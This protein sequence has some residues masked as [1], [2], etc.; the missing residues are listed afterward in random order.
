MRRLEAILHEKTRIVVK[1]GTNLLTDKLTGLNLERINSI[2]GGV[3]HLQSLGYHV[4]LVSSGAIGAGV[5]ARRLKERPRTMREKQATAAIG[6]PILMEAYEAAFRSHSRMVGQILLTKDDFVNR[7][8]YLNARNTLSVLL[9]NDV[10]PIINENDTVAVEEIKLGDNDNLS[11]MV[12]N[13]IGA[14]LLIILSDID[15][16]Y[17]DDPSHNRRAKLI[18]IVETITPRM[19]RQAKKSGGALGTGGMVTKIQA[20]KRCTSAGIAMIIANGGN[21]RV[22][23]EIVSGEFRGTLFLPAAN[24][25]NVKKKWI[26]FVSHPRGSIRIDEGAKTALTNHR[27]SLL[28]SGVLE[29][30]GVFNAKDTISVLDVMGNEIA[31]GVSGYSSAELARIRGR[32]TDDVEKVLGR[33]AHGEVIHKDNLVL[34]HP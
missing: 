2:A 30:T 22:L 28:P 7:G 21:P 10:V 31:R 12:A 26:G 16:F 5:A 33:R 3:S 34:L 29:V 25:L 23:Q 15:G 8:R 14:D 11:A 18:P 32:R 6:Q 1:I 4:A 20:A 24:R 9:E 13:L 19:E 27:K 17:S